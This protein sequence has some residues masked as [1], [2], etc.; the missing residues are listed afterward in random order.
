MDIA[1]L[2]IVFIVALPN[3]PMMPMLDSAEHGKRGD[4][5]WA[6]KTGGKCFSLLSSGTYP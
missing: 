2:E 3:G 5:G 6:S 1:S 4:L